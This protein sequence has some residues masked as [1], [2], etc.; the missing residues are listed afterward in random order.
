MRRDACAAALLSLVAA[1]SGSAA[2]PPVDAGPD[3]S[4]IGADAIGD[5]ADSAS[6]AEPWSVRVLSYNVLCS[7]CDSEEAYDPWE[8]RLAFFAD[9]FERYDPDLLGL[10]EL[11]LPDEVDQIVA[12]LPGYAALYFDEPAELPDPDATILYREARFELLDHGYYWL[13]PTPDESWSKG[14]PGGQFLPRLVGWARLRDV[15]ADRE[16]LFANTHFDANSPSQDHSAEL[17]MQRTAPLAAEVPVIFVGDLNSE[18]ASVAFTTLTTTTDYPFRDAYEL[19][20]APRQAA[21][22]VGPTPAWEPAGRIDHVLVSGANWEADDWAVDLYAYGPHS[23]VP[24]DHYPIYAH[25]SETA[26]P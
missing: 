7:F 15:E 6:V 22:A 13:S 21:N 14:F 20:A 26:A 1:C 4:D 2:P 11:A 10:Q 25:L 24:S 17:V 8:E 19:A 18:P 16:L 3:A 12:L 9:I 23:R 5:S